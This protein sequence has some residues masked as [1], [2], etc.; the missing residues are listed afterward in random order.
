MSPRCNE[1]ASVVLD[2]SQ[3]IKP[4]IDAFE[5]LS[6]IDSRKVLCYNLARLADVTPMEVRLDR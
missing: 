6:L 1:P 5:T 3:E 4:P 2:M